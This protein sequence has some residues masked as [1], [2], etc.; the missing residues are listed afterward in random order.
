MIEIISDSTLVLYQSASRHQRSVIL[1]PQNERNR[2]W[3]TKVKIIDME[4]LLTM[5]YIEG[6]I[7]KLDNIHIFSPQSMERILNNDIRHH[8]SKHE[9]VVFYSES[10]QIFCDNTMI[11]SHGYTAF[12]CPASIEHHQLNHHAGMYKR[13]FVQ[14]PTDFLDPESVAQNLDHFFCCILQPEH[15]ECIQ[16]YIDLL[17]KSGSEPDDIW[18]TITQ[19]HLLIL[20]FNMIAKFMTTDPITA[21]AQ[22]E[23]RILYKVCSYICHHFNEKITLDHLAELSFTSRATLTKRFR[24]VIGC[25][26]TE[27][28]R[29]VR[30]NY[31]IQY[32]IN[33]YTVNETAEKCGFCDAAYFIRVFQQITRKRPNEYKNP[34]TKKKEL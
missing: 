21:I 19:K 24:Q 33:G 23:D 30:I 11:R 4:K 7:E 31:A 6:E 8:H 5:Q 14:F 34:K 17:L 27:Y 20:I 32:L 15:I 22:K 12:F 29:H 18:N 2:F 9:L 16:P 1:M 26:I 13:F 28:I 10:T 3:S 25:S